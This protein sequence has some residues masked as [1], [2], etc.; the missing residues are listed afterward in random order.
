[1]EKEVRK[2]VEKNVKI[3]ERFV[4]IVDRVHG[5]HHPEFHEVKSIFE[6]IKDDMKD[7]NYDGNSVK[8]GFLKLRGITDNYKVPSDVCESYEAVYNMLKELDGVYTK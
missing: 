5:P 7:E 8:E 3:L 6:Q 1:M 4:P 2:A